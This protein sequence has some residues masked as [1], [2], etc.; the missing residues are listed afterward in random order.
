MKD[1][2]IKILNSYLISHV[3]PITFYIDEANIEDA[4]ND[5]INLIKEE[6]NEN[7]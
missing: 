6:E 4:A 2:I 5:I 3:N 7:N 1:K